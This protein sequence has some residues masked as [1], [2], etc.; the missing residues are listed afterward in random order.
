[1]NRNL[2]IAAGIFGLGVVVGRLTNDI[3]VDVT[4]NATIPVDATVPLSVGT[5]KTKATSTFGTRVAEA[6]EAT[7]R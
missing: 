2:I 7:R 1:M 5:K 3:K 6:I 4:V